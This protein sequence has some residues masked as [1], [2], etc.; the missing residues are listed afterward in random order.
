MCYTYNIRGDD[1]YSVH[2]AQEIE[3]IPE[4]RIIKSR[5]VGTT[6]VEETKWL[7]D[8]VLSY[9]SDWKRRGWAYVV[10]INEMYPVT[11]EVSAELVDFHKRLEKA[12]CRAIAFIDAGAYV[13][14]A[15]AKRHQRKSKAAYVEGH[16]KTEEDALE[17]I[18]EIL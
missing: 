11:P 15:Q 7:A 9:A 6:T 16:F 18:E 13:I 4:K 12:G 14:S 17:W 5:A 10:V 2:G 1:M 3:T 8:T